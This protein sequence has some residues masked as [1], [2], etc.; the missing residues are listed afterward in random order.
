M[1]EERNDVMM[2]VADY[3]VGH[4]RY[5]EEAHQLGCTAMSF[6]EELKDCSRFRSRK[7]PWG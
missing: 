7:L 3:A 5:V 1:D 4:Q 6:E 2:D